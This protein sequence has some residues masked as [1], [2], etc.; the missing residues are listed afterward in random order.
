MKRKSIITIFIVAFSLFQA[1]FFIPQNVQAEEVYKTFTE[2]GYGDMVQTQDAYSAFKTLSVFDEETLSRPLDMKFGP[3]E[4]IYIADTG[5]NRILVITKSGDVIRSIQHEEFSHPSGLFVDE[6]GQI[7]VADDSANK[8]FLLDAE[9]ELLHTFEKP[10]AISFGERAPFAPTKLTVDSRGNVYAL[11]R[12]NNN[13]L[14]MLNKDVEGEFLGYFAPNETSQSLLTSFRKLIFSD[15]QLDRMLST[16]PDSASNVTIDERGL[17][18]T[19]TPNENS[20]NVVKK[21]NMGGTNLLQPNYVY[22]PSGISVGQLD[23][24]FVVGE[25]GFVYEY[26]SEGELLFMFAGGDD[27]KQRRGLIGKGVAVLVDSEGV[28][29]TLDEKKSEIQA[30]TP[31]EFTQTLHRALDLYQNGRYVESKEPW[32]EVLNMNSQFDFANLGVGEAY[33]KEEDY[34]QAM[35]AFRRAKSRSGYSDAFWEVRNV[36]IR[37]NIIPVMGII[38]A[39]GIIFQLL[40]YFLPKTS[41]GKQLSKGVAKFKSIKLVKEIGFLGYYWMHPIDGAYGIRKEKKTSNLSVILIGIMALVVYVCDKYFTGF[42]FRYT[43]DGV[44]TLGQD[45]GFAFLGFFAI[46][47]A[48]Y[49][50]CTISDGSSTFRQLVHG[51][52][53]SLSPYIF[54]KPFAILASNGL[55]LNESFILQFANII[56]YVWIITIV[57]ITIKELNEYTFKQTV[58]VIFLGAFTLFIAA[59]SMFILYSLFQQLFSFIASLYGEVVHRLGL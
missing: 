11:S 58:R 5:N 9:G 18:Y 33:Y 7:Y 56:T 30:F 50:V 24:V 3:N 19:V 6:E 43:R 36:W 25:D 1:L 38:L 8:I 35:Q 48:T 13:G 40:K 45:I 52:V 57:F 23:N 37:Q 39:I 41:F 31:T 54:I 47:I 27:G 15:E 34:P 53:Y 46:V 4:D 44:Y 14:I 49:L 51:C 29:Y 21:L 12:G 59:L 26:T 22:F 16:T 32:T 10:T 55:T 42:I 17:I 28:V 20:R 2:N